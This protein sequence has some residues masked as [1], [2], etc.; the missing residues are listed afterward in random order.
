[1]LMIFTSVSQTLTKGILRA[2]GD[3]RFLMVADVLFL[4]LASIPLGYLAGIRLDLAPGIVFIC[5]KIDEVIKAIWCSRRL[6]GQRWIKNVAR[7]IQDLK[8]A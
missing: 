8:I 4:W 7:E 1:M 6:L 5:L 2:G 3:T